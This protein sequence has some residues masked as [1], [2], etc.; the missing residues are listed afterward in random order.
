MGNNEQED[1]EDIISS[2]SESESESEEDEDTVSGFFLWNRFCYNISLGF[3]RKP[4][5]SFIYVELIFQEGNS[6]NR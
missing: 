3:N 6:R 4:K 1:D 2:G 5:S